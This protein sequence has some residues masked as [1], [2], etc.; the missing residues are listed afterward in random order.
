MGCG[1]PAPLSMEFSRQEYWSGLPCPYSGDLPDPGIEP[2]S[3]ILQADSLL[4]EPRFFR[5]FNFCFNEKS[6]CL[7]CTSTKCTT[8]YILWT[9]E[10]IL[11]NPHP[12]SSPPGVYFTWGFK[13]EY[14]LVHQFLL[15]RRLFEMSISY[16]ILVSLLYNNE[17]NYFIP[18]KFG[19]NVIYTLIVLKMHVWK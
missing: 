13:M 5:L 2:G 18:L 9:L 12:S 1:P 3:L 14:W 19:L 7:L 11:P 16:P 10:M 8:L 17:R 6:G 4:F 15:F